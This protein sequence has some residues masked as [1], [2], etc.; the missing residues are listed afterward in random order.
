MGF[1]DKNYAATKM[2]PWK[3]S[4]NKQLLNLPILLMRDSLLAE[5]SKGILLKENQST[6]K[7]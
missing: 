4:R 1:L 2:N 3:R 7:Y 6:N 5:G